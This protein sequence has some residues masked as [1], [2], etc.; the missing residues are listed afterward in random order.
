MCKNEVI[1]FE[2]ASLHPILPCE[3]SL[4]PVLFLIGATRKG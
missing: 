4:Q 1:L 2:Q 3:T